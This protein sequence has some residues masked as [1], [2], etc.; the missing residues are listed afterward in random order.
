[1]TTRSCTAADLQHHGQAPLSEPRWAHDHASTYSYK[2][3]APWAATET[4]LH[5][6]ARVQTCLLLLCTCESE[7]T[8]AAIEASQLPA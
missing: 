1:M 4:C 5:A 6:G 2:V 8:Q 7:H 3:T